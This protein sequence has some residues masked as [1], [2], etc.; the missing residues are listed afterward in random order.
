[1]KH[2]VLSLLIIC[3]FSTFAQEIQRRLILFGDAGEINEEQEGLLED[4]A[5]LVISNKTSVFFLGDNIYP[6]GMGLTKDEAEHTGAILR[7]QYGAFVQKGSPTYFIAGNHDWDK[8]GPQG[9]AKVKAQAAFLKNQGEALVKFLPEPGTAELA[10]LPLTDKVIAVLYD[11]EYWLFPHHNHP[12]S[13]LEGVV[14][15]TFLK[16]LRQLIQQNSD[17]TI[18][19]ISHHP[20]QSY[21]EHAVKFSW[22]DHLFPLTRKWKS[23]YVPLPVLGS[24]YPLLRSTVL[25]SAEDLPHPHYKRLVRD[26]YE[27]VGDHQNVIFISGHDH[28]LQYIER[29][30]RKQ[31]VSGSGAKTSF[32]SGGKGSKYRHN[33]Q[34]FC[35]LDCLDDGSLNLSFYIYSNQQVKKAYEK[36]ITVN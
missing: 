12:D 35:T 25:R 15:E 20:M 28:G 3:C 33:E 11:S 27:Q 9:L 32:I 23:A 1:M 8:S 6:L 16:V 10:T 21:G 17:K 2:F 29:E 4:A 5:N 34:G 7:S 30:G 36:S 22:R 31:I 24:I 13:A 19:L 14:R 18:L 26:V